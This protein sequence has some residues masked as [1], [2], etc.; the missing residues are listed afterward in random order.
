VV[1]ARSAHHRSSIDLEEDSLNQLHVEFHGICVLL[2]RELNPSLNLPAAH[3][4]V[5]PFVTDRVPW[6]GKTVQ[7]HA[8]WVEIRSASG[9]RHS[10]PLN[11]TLALESLPGTQGV[12]GSL[13]CAV[14]LKSI[15]PDMVLDKA[16]VTEQRSPA[17]AYFDI[18]QGTLSN[19]SIEGSA[20]TRLT[21][22]TT[23]A[24]A[25][26]KKTMWNG[27][28]ENI[29]ILL[30][31]TPALILFSNI[32]KAKDDQ[33]DDFIL[34]FSVGTVFPPPESIEPKMM[35]ILLGVSNCIA[36]PIGDLGPGCSNSTF[37]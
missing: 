19:I 12:S 3:R 9:E 28:I 24:K 6:R 8:P 35:E 26:L 25:H 20:A 15:Y 21:I 22:E 11:V 17:A 4:V 27:A 7:V 32:A 14:P 36:S 34:N 31:E 18:D 16:V 2:S 30:E 33:L 23:A 10:L 5:L 1:V 13:P 37:P 29:P